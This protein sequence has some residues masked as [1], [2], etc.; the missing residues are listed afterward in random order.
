M[1]KIIMSILFTTLSLYAGLINAIA[2]TVNGTPITL[3]DIDQTMEN[4]KVS[5][6][7]AVSVLI[8]K[9]LYDEAL[10]TNKVIVDESNINEY[11]AQLAASNKM[12]L[13]EFKSL[14]KQQQNYTLFQAQIKQQLIH[15]KLIRKISS[16][17]LSIA[18]ENDLKI[19]YENNKEQFHVA[20]SI[21]VVAYVSKDKRDLEQLKQNPMLQ[22][23]NIVSQNITMKQNEMNAQT[24]YIINSTKGKNFTAIFS[25]NNNFN[26]FYIQNKKDVAIL[27]YDEVK[28][29]IFQMIMK[30]R[31]SDYLKEYF[32]TA[33]ITAEINV[34][35]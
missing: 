34:L 10:D 2:I 26:M 13:E 23:Q 19:Y 16:G 24:K 9:I 21:D 15:Q 28:E 35:Q 14:V 7:Q 6:E 11:I 5:K 18:S 33:K 29:R 30:K 32:E 22:S 4:T 31:E 27:T 1:K 17:N 25:Q 8:D 3:Y 20:D 12:G